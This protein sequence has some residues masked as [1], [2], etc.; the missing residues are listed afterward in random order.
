MTAL[1]HRIARL[2]TLLICGATA[3]AGA[4]H[5]QAGAPA[6]S[7]TSVSA[8]ASPYFARWTVSE[9]RPVFTARGRMYKTIDIARC[10]RDF[11]GVSVNDSGLCGPTLFRFLMSHAGGEDS[12]RGHGKWGEARMNVMLDN[13]EDDEAPGGRRVEIYLGKGYDF[14]ERSDNMPK[15][16]AAYRKAGA[17]RCT[18]R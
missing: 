14:G 13:Y 16:H 17:A 5:L 4:A 3:F 2:S 11:C 10:G 8:G 1:S 18:A 9:E 6:A 7:S 15:F 12:L